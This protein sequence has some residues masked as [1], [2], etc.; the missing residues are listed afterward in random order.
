[1]TERSILVVDVD[2]TLCPIKSEGRRYE[3]L[4]PHQPMVRRLRQWRAAA[5]SPPAGTSS[6]A[7]WRRALRPFVRLAQADPVWLHRLDGSHPLPSLLPGV[8]HVLLHQL[9]L[10]V[11]ELAHGPCQVPGRS[12]AAN[13]MT[14]V[15]V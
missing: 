4:E 3:D 6:C 5:G 9:R 8:E 7:A 13:Q 10:E 2:G 14:V 15:R 1:M 11:W 12:V